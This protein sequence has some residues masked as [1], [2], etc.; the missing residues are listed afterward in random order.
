MDAREADPQSVI[1]DECH[2][3]GPRPGSPR[4]DAAFPEEQHDSYDNLIVLCKVHHKMVD[5]QPVEFG[6][7]AL[8]TLKTRHEQRVKKA[9]HSR[10]S[11]T[12]SGATQS[13][14]N[15]IRSGRELLQVLI[16]SYA[17]DFDHD[18]PRSQD[19]TDLIASTLQA[20]HDW[21]EVGDDLEPGQRVQVG[22]ELTAEIKT[23]HESR[24]VILGAQLRRPMRVGPETQ[25]WPVAM[26]RI[27]HVDNP[28]LR[29]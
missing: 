5:D 12:S 10:S 3:V 18:E 28:I 13:R 26:I 15:V 21:G 19:E 1:G 7:D 20:L 16:G 6:A 9:L 29:P 23:L 25:V 2:I 14:L 17:Y 8:R 24:L 27:F 11:T 4:Y 22:Y